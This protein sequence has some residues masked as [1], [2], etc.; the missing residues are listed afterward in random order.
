MN[1]LVHNGVTEPWGA[2][3]AIIEIRVLLSSDPTSPVMILRA[4]LVATREG[5]LT[6]GVF[7]RAS[8]GSTFP[9]PRRG[10]DSDK[11]KK[12]RSLRE[13]HNY[14]RVVSRDLEKKQRPKTGYL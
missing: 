9:A 13:F 1:F 3:T 2:D 14:P 12:H 7:T 4:Y 11:R 10:G 6:T 5:S 8:A